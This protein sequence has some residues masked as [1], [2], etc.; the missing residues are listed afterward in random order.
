MDAS[1][2]LRLEF[3]RGWKWVFKRLLVLVEMWMEV[4]RFSGYVFVGMWMEVGIWLESLEAAVKFGRR[5]GGSGSGCGCVCAGLR[6]EGRSFGCCL[7]CRGGD[8]G[9]GFGGVR[10]IS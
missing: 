3:G 9:R 1:F 2:R 5:V 4:G 10:L 7:G 8:V 6:Y